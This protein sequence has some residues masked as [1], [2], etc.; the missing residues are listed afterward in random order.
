MIQWFQILI[1]KVYLL[2]LSKVFS[3]TRFPQLFLYRPNEHAY[4]H[5]VSGKKKKKLWFSKRFLKANKK[6]NVEQESFKFCLLLRSPKVFHHC[7]A[8]SSYPWSRTIRRGRD[9]PHGRAPRAQ[10]CRRPACLARRPSMPPRRTLAQWA[11]QDQRGGAQS[12]EKDHWPI[13]RLWKTVTWIIKS[14]SLLFFFTIIVAII[15]EIY[16]ACQINI[17]IL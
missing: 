3:G 8:D 9:W 1:T 7:S 5:I 14:L 6:K 10:T 17:T 4:W 2:F 16:T 12:S 11:G 13:F 15:K